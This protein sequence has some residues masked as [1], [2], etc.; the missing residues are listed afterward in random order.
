MITTLIVDD[1]PAIRQGLMTSLQREPGIVPIAA[2]ADTA[3]A[4]AT[5]RRLA[6]RCAVVDYQLG[7][8]DG[9]DLVRGLCGLAQPPGVV[10]YSAFAKPALVIAGK[11]AGASGIVGKGAPLD[12]IIDAIK[13]ASRRESVIPLPSPDAVEETVS[14]IPKDARPVLAMMLDGATSDEMANV[15]HLSATETETR[16]RSLFSAFRELLWR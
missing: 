8:E 4:I 6:P 12:E 2:V 9:L 11:A 5:A 16:V 1:H 14:R 7:A 15:L 10:L 3:A 13:Q